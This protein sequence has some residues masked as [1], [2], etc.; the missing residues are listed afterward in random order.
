MVGAVILGMLAG[1]IGPALMPGKD[2]MGFLAK[3]RIGPRRRT[4]RPLIFTTL[5][6][7]GDTDAFDS[8]G[9]IGAAIGVMLLLAAGRALQH[10]K[11]DRRTE[12]RRPKAFSLARS[13]AVWRCSVSERITRWRLCRACS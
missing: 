1:F 3:G 9:L 11:R 13:L 10:E 12:R 5:L 7:I 6:G 4:G 8:G 2:M